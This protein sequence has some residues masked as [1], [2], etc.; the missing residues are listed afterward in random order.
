MTFLA[1]G[2]ECA[3][4]PGTD[5]ALRYVRDRVNVPRDMPLWSARRLRD[6]LERTAALAGDAQA[7]PIQARHR[8]DQD[9]RPFLQQ[10]VMTAA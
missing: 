2:E 4:P 9:P 10:P 7:T 1:S 6:A 5:A 3:P 8:R